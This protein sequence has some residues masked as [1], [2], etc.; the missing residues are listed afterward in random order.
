MT[1]K[2]YSQKV[3]INDKKRDNKR[4]SDALNK[5]GSKENIHQVFNT[6]YKDQVRALYRAVTKES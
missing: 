6:Y 5:G 2:R 3:T 1:V 4:R